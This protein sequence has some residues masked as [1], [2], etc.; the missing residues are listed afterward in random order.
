[1]WKY[2][3]D[4]IKEG[5]SFLYEVS[6]CGYRKNL[7]ETYNIKYYKSKIYIKDVIYKTF[8]KYN[9][10]ILEKEIKLIEAPLKWLKQNAIYIEPK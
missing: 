5:D 6:L 1:M 8:Y 3:D 4:Y 7:F 9:T 2:N 10:F